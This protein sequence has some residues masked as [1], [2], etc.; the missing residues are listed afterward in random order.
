MI[1]IMIMILLLLLLLRRRR[2]RRS[3]F[4]DSLHFFLKGSGRKPGTRGMPIGGRKYLVG[5][6]SSAFL[7]YMY[8]HKHMCIYIYI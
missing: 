3:G 1:M 4:S 2:R 7:Y 6:A 8:I 5:V